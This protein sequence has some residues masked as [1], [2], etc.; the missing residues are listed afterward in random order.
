M[1][2]EQLSTDFD[3]LYSMI[4]NTNN[5]KSYSKLMN[6]TTEE[7]FHRYK[8]ELND[9]SAFLDTFNPDAQSGELIVELNISDE[10]EITNLS[11]EKKSSSLELFIIL[12]TVIGF[13]LF[14]LS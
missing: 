9:E 14:T 5:A 12:S 1:L 6:V 7:I 13:L 8:K 3:E 11:N 10:I 4:K 2:V